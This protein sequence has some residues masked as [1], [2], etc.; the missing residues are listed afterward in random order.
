MAQRSEPE[1]RQRL[2]EQSPVEIV[3]VE[4]SVLDR[5]CAREELLHEPRRLKRV[6]GAQPSTRYQD[7]LSFPRD[8]ALIRDE[9]LHELFEDS[10]DRG[11]DRLAVICGDVRL[12]YRELDDRANRLARWLRE[13]GFDREDRVAIWLPRSER[14]YVAMLGILKAGA[15]YVPVDFDTP[16]ERVAFILRD[17]GAKCLLTLS[18]SAAALGAAVPEGVVVLRLDRDAAQIDRQPPVRVPR[19]ET[20]AKR[21]DLCYVIYTSGTTG[22][23]KGVQ[24]EH[25][26]VTNLVRAESKLYGVGPE[27]RVFQ[28]ASPAFDASVEEIW[29]A[30]FHGAVLVAGTRETIRPGRE[31]SDI[32]ERFGVTVLSCVPTFCAMLEGDLPTVRTLI[33]GGEPFPP[34]LASRWH[35]PGRAIFN[36][37]GPTEATVIA[38][39]AALSPDRP[40]T[41]GR[42]IANYAV[43]L[44]DD[45]QRPVAVGE[46]GEICI[47]GEGVARGYRNRPEL[48]RERSIVAQTPA[49]AM[50]LYRTGDLARW[51]PEGELEYLGRADDQVKIR[52]YRVELSEIEACLVECSGVRAAAAALHPDTQRIA[53]YVVPG[54]GQKPD[55]ATLR[56]RLATRLPPYMVPAFL[57]EVDALPMTTSGKIDRKRLPP[58]RAPLGEAGGPR[59]APRNDAERTVLGVFES[60][61]GRDGISIHD[62]FF[63][64]LDG[65]SL[66]AAV[67][68][69]HL[70]RLPG[71]ER[72]SVGDLYAHPTVEGLAALARG[73]SAASRA[74]P[75]QPQAA[76]HEASTAAYRFCA[77]GQAFGVVFLAGIYAWQ[78]LGPFLAY[79]YEVAG[80]SP[81][82]HALVITLIVSVVTT[83]AM[84]A[85][86]IALKWLLMGRIRP[87][88]HPLWGWY[89]LRFWFVREVIRAT[90]IHYLDGTPLLNLYYR[91]MGARIGRN[92][93]IGNHCV[94]TFDVLTVGSGSS[95]GLDAT[96]DGASVE[97]GMLK[98]APVTIGRECW[99]GNRCT[100]GADAVIEDGA[101]LGDLSMLPGGARVPAG[102][103]WRG[104]PAAP[105]GRLEPEVSGAPWSV[106]TSLAHAGGVFVLPL[107]TLAALFPG[108]MVLTHLGHIDAGLTFLLA[109]PVAALL[110]VGGLCGELWAVKWLVIGRLKEGRYPLSGS[111]Y[112]RKWFFDRLMSLSFEVTE[113][114]YETLYVSPWLRALG[115]R[116]GPRC[117]IEA[118]D[119]VQPDLLTVGA[120]SF[121]ADLVLVGAPHVRSGWMTIGPVRLGERS[122]VGNSAIL[123]AHAW[124]GDNVLVGVLSMPPEAERGRVPDG[125]TWFGSPPMHLPTRYKSKKFSEAE[126][127]RPPR[128][129]V[130]L[131]LAI[132]FFRVLMPCSIFV[133]LAS[134]IINTMHIIQDYAGLLGW[135]AALPFLYI[136][137]G[138]LGVLA[139]V[140]TKWS[141]IGRYQPGE[142]PFWCTFVWRN[143]MVTGVYQNLCDLFFLTLLRGTPFIAWV[144]RALGMKVGRRCYI[145]STWFTEFD[146]VEIGDEAALN[147]NAN[148]QTHLFEDRIIK[149]GRVRVGPRCSVGA[150]STVLYDTEMAAESWL[151]DLSLIMKG[152]SLPPGT[153]WHGIPARREA[154][155]NGSS[156]GASNGAGIRSGERPTTT[157]VDGSWTTCCR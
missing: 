145:D 69:S 70:R 93:F 131:R 39:A 79:G 1:R 52:G 41:I 12:S 2:D 130:A 42:P 114:L 10:V 54:S 23:P 43:V 3:L 133:I 147:E 19:D 32:L 16:V 37:Y 119:L 77:L 29:L 96:L 86:S 152:E 57:D 111:F 31:F 26:S 4:E 105:A 134:L 78:W 6:S 11:P 66:L 92:V 14:V 13:R 153:R 65:H 144:L 48:D 124:L 50:R 61:L 71:F 101:G 97:G 140:L 46:Q 15:A 67:A 5:T 99:V 9:L 87:G 17:S 104:S 8:P 126:T 62:D 143:D 56:E 157:S 53:A 137:A 73:P 123:P 107:F 117:E 74:R 58:P 22:Q 27:D 115:A 98:I 129:L 148:L 49:G 122:F 127:Y 109:S 51:T 7:W 36:T 30:F 95:I 64:Q 44:L 68:V 125:E 81:V 110:M 25:R 90:P 121:I 149:M 154:D 85:L 82:R 132:E 128:R 102:E 94:T 47:G 100:V 155:S 151:G 75:A 135:L 24:I 116:I 59:V 45:S 120:E 63:A 106:A 18:D 20:R 112:L 150:M 60:V 89:Y 88:S 108:I 138:T 21:E 84:L 55:R 34:D 38:T 91:L 76:F 118:I 72:I 33:L 40:V 28:L 80:G 136:G 146:L 141:L 156:S 139:T 103:L 113:T 35:R 142:K 83:P